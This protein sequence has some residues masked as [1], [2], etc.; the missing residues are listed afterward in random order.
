MMKHYLN[1]TLWVSGHLCLQVAFV[2]SYLRTLSTKKWKGDRQGRKQCHLMC[3][4]S[5]RTLMLELLEL[6]NELI[7]HN[8]FRQEVRLSLGK[9]SDEL[10][11]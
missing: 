10:H 9:L 11:I 3:Q 5:I 8:H 4:I 6:A 1:K 7:K 2:V